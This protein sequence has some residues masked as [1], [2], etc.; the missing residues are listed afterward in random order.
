MP[1]DRVAQIP[2]LMLLV[3]PAGFF[4]AATSARGRRITEAAMIHKP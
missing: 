3:M 2:A 1:A 4:A